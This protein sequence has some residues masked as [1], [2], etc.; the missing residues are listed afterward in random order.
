MPF[1]G[2]DEFQEANKALDIAKEIMSVQTTDGCPLIFNA[3]IG[4]GVPKGGF[5]E[6]ETDVRTPEA[7]F[8]FNISSKIPVAYKTAAQKHSLNVKDNSRGFLSNADGEMLI[9]FI[10]FGSS[11]ASDKNSN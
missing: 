3:H 10:N 2:F 7:K 8:L 1:N 4:N 6:N 5:E 9:K 11:A